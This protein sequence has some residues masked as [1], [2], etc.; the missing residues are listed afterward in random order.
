MSVD[1]NFPFYS[2][3]SKPEFPFEIVVNKKVIHQRLEIPVRPQ[4]KREKLPVDSRTILQCPRRVQAKLH[5]LKG[6][7]LGI[8]QVVVVRRLQI[9]IADETADLKVL[10]AKSRVKIHRQKAA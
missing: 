9:A 7:I 1:S 10:P 5:E 6:S 3:G 8:Y 4:F 2:P